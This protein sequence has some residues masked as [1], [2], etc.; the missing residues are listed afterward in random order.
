MATPP[1][2]KK[3]T[4]TVLKNLFLLENQNKDES[5]LRKSLTSKTRKNIWENF[6]AKKCA[7]R[8]KKKNKTEKC[9]AYLKLLMQD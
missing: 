4:G 2:E 1:R 8:P 9:F 6:I 7:G 5:I 3:N